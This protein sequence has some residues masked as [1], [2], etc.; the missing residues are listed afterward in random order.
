M[1][2][3]GWVDGSC[4]RALLARRDGQ[5]RAPSLLRHRPNFCPCRLPARPPIHPLAQP[6]AGNATYTFANTTVAC[7]TDPAIVAAAAAAAQ[8]DDGPPLPRWVGGVVG[9]AAATFVFVGSVCAALFVRR[10]R[11]RQREAGGQPGKDPEAPEELGEPL[12][13]PTT[14]G[15][16]PRGGGEEGG[17]EM[18][19]LQLTPRSSAAA[20][21]SRGSVGDMGA[22]WRTRRVLLLLLVLWCSSC[23]WARASRQSARASPRHVRP[24]LTLLLPCCLHPSPQVWPAG[25][26]GDWG[27]AG[28]GRV[29]KG[30]PRPLERRCVCGEGGGAPGGHRCAFEA[31]SLGIQAFTC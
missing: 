5:L 23:D 31:A 17:V 16:T 2:V 12:T 1:W 15:S 7:A 29:W 25:W 22:V 20:A 11:R 21:A 4:V 14:R 13:P 28:Q 19:A 10:Q 30:V 6:P 26:A 27:H 24:P 9:A 18:Q 3:G 8:P